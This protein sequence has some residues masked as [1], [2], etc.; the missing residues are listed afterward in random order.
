MELIY[1]SFNL[2]FKESL[3]HCRVTLKYFGPLKAV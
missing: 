1:I 2:I 3:A